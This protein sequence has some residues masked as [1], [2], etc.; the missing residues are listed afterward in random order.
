MA[1]LRHRVGPTLLV[2]AVQ[3]LSTDVVCG[4]R[5]ADDLARFAGAIFDRRLLGRELACRA[6]AGVFLGEF[7]KRQD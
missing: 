6:T 1:T 5:S 7:L 2:S 4:G 3:G